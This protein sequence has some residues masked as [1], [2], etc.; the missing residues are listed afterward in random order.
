MIY[1]Y[2]CKDCDKPFSLKGIPMADSGKIQKCPVCKG[3]NTER[4]FN[5]AKIFVPEGWNQPCKE[6]LKRPIKYFPMGKKNSKIF[7]GGDRG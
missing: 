1:S 5:A 4:L 7:V 6:A 2:N 3:N